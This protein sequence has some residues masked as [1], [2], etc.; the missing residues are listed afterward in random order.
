MKK[1]YAI[2][3]LALATT[4]FG[5]RNVDLSA[6]LVTP[7][8]E[9]TVDKNPAQVLKFTFQIDPAK[10]TLVAGDSLFFN[11]INWN[12]VNPNTG[13]GF[14]SLNGT[15]MQTTYIVVPAQAQ[16]LAML[17]SGQPVPSAMLNNGADFTFNTTQ[18]GMSTGDEL[19]VVI[20]FGALNSN[21]GADTTNFTNNISESFYLGAGTV[22]VSVVDAKSFS[23]YPNP[24][25]ATM[26]ISAA[27][28]VTS[29][30]IMT[31]DGKA[32]FTTNGNVVN[33]ST[34]ASGVYF[35]E[36]TTVSGAKAI[37]KFIKE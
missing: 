25:T 5:Q 14:F 12:T 15:P 13:A 18:T 32:V 23:A 37:N 35:Y 4:A 6:N 29:V 2:V 16:A 27:E 8:A 31:L 36:A 19:G 10:D 9:T 3:A 20:D 22:A 17:N 1:I 21:P 34:L 7:V 11:V 30:S 26:T 28:E 24:A 33:V